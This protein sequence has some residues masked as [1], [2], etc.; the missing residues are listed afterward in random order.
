MVTPEQ[1]PKVKELVAEALEREPSA[2]SAFLDE[3]C[4][5]NQS[6]RAEVE[7]LLHSHQKA[8]TV[9]LKKPAFDLSAPQPDRENGSR[10][11]RR[12]G[13]Y[14][15]IEQIGHGGMGEVYR[16]ERADGQ[17]DKQVAV[18]LIRPGLDSA[19]IVE[20]FRNER[21]ILAG[22]DHPN[23]AKLLDGGTSE[24]GMPYFVMELIEGQPITGY[25]NQ[26]DLSIGERLKLFL[27]VCAAVHYAH[28]HLIIHRDIKPGNILVTADGIPK[29]LDFGI[30]K[31]VESG[32][33]AGMPEATLTSFRILTPRYASPE[34]MNGEGDD[35]RHGRVLVG[36]SS[37]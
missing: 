6:L 3:A 4:S 25:C 34:Q 9:F 22:L 8:G 5:Q 26:H 20:R 11:G 29:L 28:Q 24:A 31:I 14:H 32:Q 10:V 21:Q 7:S 19:A 16:A 2:R 36:R 37:V 27:R 17:Y 18:K 33:D 12:V 15:L 35:D 1:W 30:A 13:V 23:L